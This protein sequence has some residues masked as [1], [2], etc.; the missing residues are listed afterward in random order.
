MGKG[1]GWFGVVINLLVLAIGCSG[2]KPT[3]E[4]EKALAMFQAVQQSLEE[5]PSPQALH[6]LLGQTE[7]ELNRLKQNPR[8]QPCFVNALN[9][10]FASYQIINKAL[11]QKKGPLDEKRREEIDMALTFTTAFAAVSIKQAMDCYNR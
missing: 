6:R 2:P 4:E 5:S 7:S 1:I 8:T 10:C 3:V 11:D 9:K